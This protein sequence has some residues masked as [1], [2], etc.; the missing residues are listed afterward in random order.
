MMQIIALITT[1]I[2][3]YLIIRER[4]N[5]RGSHSPQQRDILCRTYQRRSLKRGL[6]MRQAF[7]VCKRPLVSE[8][9]RFV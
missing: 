7:A 8:T 9:I 4:S 5:A 6:L 1:Q 3:I 2:Q